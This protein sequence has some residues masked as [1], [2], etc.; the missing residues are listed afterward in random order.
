[1]VTAITRTGQRVVGLVRSLE[2]RDA[3]KPV[4]GL[5]WTVGQTAAH[6]VG[7]TRRGTGDRRRAATVEKLGDLNMIQI[8][9]IAEED[10]SGIADQLETLL[11]RQLSQLSRATGDEPFELHA[12][13]FAS[14]KTALSY[15]L[16]DFLVHGHDI[17]RATGRGWTIDPSDAALDVLAILPALEPWLREEIRSGTTKHLRFTFP[18][19]WQ[20][21]A[22]QVGH[23]RYHVGLQE[24]NTAREL[25]PVETLLALARREK[26]RDEVISELS[27]WYLPT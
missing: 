14:I 26:S 25:D 9:E 1:M 22:V 10:P 11:D 18:Q 23:G 12:G 17:A 7:I 8:T 3:G 16:W 21:I 19:I 15:E 6:L 27:S 24:D 4:P 5:E 2:L 13:L 20:A